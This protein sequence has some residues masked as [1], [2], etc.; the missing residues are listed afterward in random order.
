MAGK[1]LLSTPEEGE[2][3][4]Q[5]LSC[6]YPL[7]R[8]QDPGPVSKESGSRNQKALSLNVCG[9]AA[10]VWKVPASDTK[11]WLLGQGGIQ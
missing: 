8:A 11:P 10:R 2:A 6:P 4:E 5:S 3:K 1:P 9:K 7:P